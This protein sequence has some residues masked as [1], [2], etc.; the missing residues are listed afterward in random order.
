[1]TAIQ[2][3][4][5]FTDLSRYDAETAGNPAEMLRRF[6]LG[7]T[8]KWRTL[9][10]I[11]PCETYQE[12]YESMVRIE[13]SENM[14]SD[15]EEEEVR[16]SNQ[17]RHDKGKGKGQLSQGPRQ[18]QSF[19]K[20]GNS[21][22]LLVEVSV[23]QDRGEEVDPLEDPAFRGLESQ[24]VHVHRCAVGATTCILENVVEAIADVTLVDRQGICLS[25]AHR[26]HRDFSHPSSHSRHN[27][28]ATTGA[29]SAVFRTQ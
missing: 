10:T 6:K 23:P 9:V 20:S 14:P 16:G 15:S 18:T 24:L 26:I 29:D 4:R 28:L 11:L 21:S 19:K 22:S 7:A 5:R 25:I 17:L 12:F 2:Y 3:Y 27:C 13:D 8:K 1:M